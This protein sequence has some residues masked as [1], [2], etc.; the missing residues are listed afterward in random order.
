MKI[1][2]IS[3]IN[4]RQL[5]KE[6]KK[7]NQFFHYLDLTNITQNQINT[8]EKIPSDNL[9]SRAKRMVQINDI[10]I[11]TVRPNNKHHGIMKKIPNNLL[12]STGF[13]VISVDEEKADPYYIYYYLSSYKNQRRLE[14]I[15]N[16][17]T[18]SYPSLRPE[19]IQ[20]LK[21][22]DMPIEYQRKAGKK[23]RL[24]EEKLSSNQNLISHL[25]EYAQLLF[26]KWFVNFNFMNKNGNPYKD[27]GGEMIEVDGKIIP[28]GWEIKPLTQIA[29]YYNGLAMQ[30]FRPKGNTSLPVLKIR[31]LKL[32][33][34][35]NQSEICD[36]CINENAKVFDGDII[37]SWSAS[38]E[39]RI[40]AGGDA[41][42]NQHLFKVTSEKYPRWFYYYWT[43][44]HVQRF[45]QIASSKKT[46]MGHINRKHLDQ[47]MSCVPPQ[48]V[49]DE[50]SWQMEPLLTQIAHLNKENLLL[51]EIHD[52]LIKKL[53]K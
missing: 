44:K 30:K 20:E 15:A 52:L 19:N 1:I 36:P 12:V 4:Q 42:L 16:T 7:A 33:H 35:D 46:T 49:I 24:I 26:H 48:D 17:S 13:T 11:S 28:K 22:T 34:T 14:L 29:S 32:G 27:S 21:S 5:T 31:E 50:M 25:E 2:D 23:L 45:T 37:F 8:I 39:V 6:I 10:I 53:I 47:A 9:P 18:S 38:L 40:W 43:K 51:Q 41:G 3:E